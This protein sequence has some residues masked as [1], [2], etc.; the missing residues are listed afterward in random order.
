MKISVS[1]EYDVKGD[2][3]EQE[4]IVVEVIQEEARKLTARVMDRL[5]ELGIQIDSFEPGE[6]HEDD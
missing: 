1:V 5:E 3:P 2:D 4:Q 6:S